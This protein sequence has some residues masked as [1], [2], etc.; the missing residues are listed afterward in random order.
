[1]IPF[2]VEFVDGETSIVEEA[3]RIELFTAIQFSK[4][5]SAS[6]GTLGV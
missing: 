1:M 5:S 3:H 2:F 6:R 4:N